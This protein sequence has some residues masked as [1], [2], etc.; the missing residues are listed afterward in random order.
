MRPGRAHAPSGHDILS[1]SA[2]SFRAG[3]PLA[4]QVLARDIAECA[5]DD[6]HADVHGGTVDDTNDHD[7]DVDHD[8]GH[9][10]YRR[11]SGVAYG[12]S[13]PVFNPQSADEPAM[14]P[15]E[16]KQSRQ[17]ERSLLRDNH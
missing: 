5:N 15:L 1:T 10:K 13:R 7:N 8:V 2:S 3:S 9:T 4:E 17:A 6:H 14:T 12:A 16:R 11:P